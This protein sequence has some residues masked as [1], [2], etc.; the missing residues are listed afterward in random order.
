MIKKTKSMLKHLIQPE[1]LARPVEVM[2]IGAGGTGSQI[3]HGLARLHVALKKCGHPHGLNVLLADGD[4]VSESNLG[5]QLFY[6]SDLGRNKA[7]VLIE[8][9]N[10]A[11]NLQWDAHPENIKS[12][13]DAVMHNPNIIIGC[14]DTRASRRKIKGLLKLGHD[15]YYMDCGNGADYGQVL[16]G[17]VA[18][19]KSKTTKLP[20]PWE[21]CP[22]LI[23]DIPED[24][25]PSCS[26]AEAL[27]SQELFINQAVATMA[28]QLLWSLFRHGGLDIRGYYINLKTGRT[29]PVPI[30]ARKVES[31]K[32]E[33]SK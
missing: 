19:A 24:N 17:F 11:Y 18:E 14:V 15:V 13:L 16:L 28:L 9:I 5:R 22:D 6:S 25:T 7:A 32:S 12:S 2:V 10:F 4:T 27:G 8:R 29:L 20:M 21:T 30:E 26:L 3:V 31:K 1:L 23:A 33:R